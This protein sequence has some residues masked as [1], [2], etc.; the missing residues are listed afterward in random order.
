LVLAFSAVYTVVESVP[1]FDGRAVY[2]VL[3]IYLEGLIPIHLRVIARSLG[4]AIQDKPRFTLNFFMRVLLSEFGN[5]IYK[6]IFPSHVRCV[7]LLK[8]HDVWIGVSRK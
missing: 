3:T 2:F 7:F 1:T 4:V 6:S 5:H 8:I